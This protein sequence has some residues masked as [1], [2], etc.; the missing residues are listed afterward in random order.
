MN[1]DRYKTDAP[2]HDTGLPHANEESLK[3]LIKGDSMK[4]EPGSIPDRSTQKHGHR[5][6]HSV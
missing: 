3:T 2:R 6:T 4:H 5:R 1:P